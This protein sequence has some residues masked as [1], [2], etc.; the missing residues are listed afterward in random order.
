SLRREPATLAVSDPVS[1]SIEDPERRPAAA[2]A[3][4]SRP[5][6][7]AASAPANREAE[8]GLSAPERRQREAAPGALTWESDRGRA[9]CGRG[10]TLSEVAGRASFGVRSARQFRLSVMLS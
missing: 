6:R 5:G 4:L 10:S 1:A 2:H 3:A 9:V 8:A 7:R